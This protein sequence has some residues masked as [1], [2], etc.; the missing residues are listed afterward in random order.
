MEGVEILDLPRGAARLHAGSCNLIRRLCRCN[1]NWE[2]ITDY[3]EYDLPKMKSLREH[4]IIENSSPG[5][6]CAR[7]APLGCEQRYIL[8]NS[9]KH[10][11]VEELG[12]RQ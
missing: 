1:D 2:G 11:E 4:V 8:L 3:P 6:Q 10:A 9:V 12:I 5:V 7:Y